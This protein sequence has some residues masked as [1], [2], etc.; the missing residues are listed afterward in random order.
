MRRYHVDEFGAQGDG[1]FDNSEA[2]ASA[3]HAIRDGGVLVIPK[4][5]YRTGP[6][7]LQGQ[8]CTIHIEAGAHLSFIAEEERYRPVFTR[9]EGVDCWAMHPLLLV[10][11]SKDITLNGP[12]TLDGN[13]QWWWQQLAHKRA[14][15][16]G[17]QSTIE[18]ELAA[19]NPSYPIQSGG[20]GGR[21]I[22]FLRPPLLQVHKSSNVIIDG[23]TLT[24]SPFWTLH[25]LYSSH[26]LI[27]DVTID[28]PS[29]APNT[30]GIDIESCSSVV[31][32]GCT[33]SVGD[34]GIALKSGSGKDGIANGVPTVDVLIEDCTVARAHGGAV[35]G[36][37]TAAGISNVTVRNCRFDGTDR[38]IRIKTRRGRGGRIS[39]L[40]FTNLTM[41][42][43]LCPLAINMYYRCGSVDERDFSLDAL[44]V[45]ET[46]P[47]IEGVRV[48]E[49]RAI[50]SRASAAFIVGLPEAPITDLFIKD[51]HFG[52][53]SNTLVSTDESEM[54]EGLA[55]T[56]GRGIRIR[57]AHLT[58]EGVTV[59]GV[60]EALVVEEGAL[61]G[62][63]EAVRQH[64]SLVEA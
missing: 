44:P 46:T 39:N 22:Q 7:Y 59:E 55:S 14:H 26:L 24:N 49:C 36:S 3:F 35:I 8:G 61:L 32:R 17:P 10:T 43:N 54:F 9:W 34:D 57:N 52:V 33:V 60:K 48:E 13:G 50:G 58:L 51:C 29:D 25:P 62:P 11:D 5:V 30:D 18:R 4:G 19:L 12:G 47:Q 28:N 2:L 37:E 40:T 16:S 27:K 42:D 20:G 23:L 41:Q 15:Q 45:S 1:R 63:K 31:V 38:G 53:S 6:L 64:A 56:T 21:Q